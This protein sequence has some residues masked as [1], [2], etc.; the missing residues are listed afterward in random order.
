[1]FLSSDQIYIA[2]FIPV[3]QLMLKTTGLNKDPQWV[4]TSG[5]VETMM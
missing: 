5:T 4:L 3:V 1:M 2:D